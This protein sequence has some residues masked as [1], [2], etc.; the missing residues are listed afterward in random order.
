MNNLEEKI[1]V[2]AIS[3]QMAERALDQLEDKFRIDLGRNDFTEK[4]QI[5]TRLIILSLTMTYVLKHVTW[6]YTMSFSIA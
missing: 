3:N 4:N 6:P 1:K 5:R 2:F